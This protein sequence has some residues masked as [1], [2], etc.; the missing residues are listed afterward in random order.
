MD[1][2]LM[3]VLKLSVAQLCQC[4]YTVNLTTNKHM[5]LLDSIHLILAQFVVQIVG[6]G[7]N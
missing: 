3:F 6:N 1:R 2:T 4:T 7:I 5:Y